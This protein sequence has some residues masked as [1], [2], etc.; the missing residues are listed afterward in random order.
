MRGPADRPPLWAAPEAAGPGRP[1][2][3]RPADTAVRPAETARRPGRP[4][5]AYA[6]FESRGHRVFRI[7]R[8][9]TVL[10]II[11]LG[12]GLALAAAIGG[13]VYAIAAALH[14]AASQ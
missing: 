1:A 5:A 4:A 13:I 10:I 2:A 14:H 7:V 9:S 12:L 11:A 3:V 8:S 6:A